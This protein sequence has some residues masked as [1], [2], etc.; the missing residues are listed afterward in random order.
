MIFSNASSRG[1]LLRCV[2]CMLANSFESLERYEGNL[3]V[4]D[5]LKSGAGSYLMLRKTGDKASSTTHF[6]R[7]TLPVE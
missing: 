4:T 7:M 6:I 2:S 1:Q 5:S 3:K